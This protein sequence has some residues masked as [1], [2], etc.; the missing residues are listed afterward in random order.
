M[1]LQEIE[2]LISQIPMRSY[3]IVDGDLDTPFLLG[4]RYK[5][6]SLSDDVEFIRARRIINLLI[7]VLNRHP[8]Q[9][10]VFEISGSNL[11]HFVGTMKQNYEDDEDVTRLLAI[12]NIRN[13]TH[14]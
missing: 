14:S 7:R 6:N 3:N 1:D 11:E 4:K 2:W 5:N 8:E 9:L 12:P 10:D 13:I